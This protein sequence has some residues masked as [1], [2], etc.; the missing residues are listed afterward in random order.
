M[1]R[2]V[3]A[4]RIFAYT[5]CYTPKNNPAVGRINVKFLVI[6]AHNLLV[7][8]SSPVRLTNTACFPN[9]H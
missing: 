7:A 8:G 5:L 6:F 2:C 9:K 3:V 4:Q 1:F